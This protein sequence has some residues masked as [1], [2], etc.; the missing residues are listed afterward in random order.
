MKTSL[1]TLLLGLIVVIPVTANEKV[2][3][4]KTDNPP[5]IDGILD[6]EAWENTADLYE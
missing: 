6:D 4:T 1:L 3:L 5:V 2:D